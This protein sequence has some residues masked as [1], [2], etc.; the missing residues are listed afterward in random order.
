[1]DP[2]TTVKTV[3]RSIPE[4]APS[5]PPPPNP[6]L[7]NLIK[8]T[9]VIA[10]AAPAV[11]EETGVE[12]HVLT[13]LALKL[14]NTV[15]R[16]TSDWAAQQLRLPLGVVDRIFWQLR[17][18]LLLEILGQEEGNFRYSI[19]QR[20]R[21]YA[22]RL[23]E[24][25]GYVGPAPVSLESYA[26]ML[27]WQM[28]K[29]GRPTVESVTEAISSLVLPQEAI[30][31]AS[32]AA[33]SGRSLF[34]FGPPGNGKTSL[35]R[36]LHGVLEGEL[37]IPHCVS[38][39]SHIIRIFDPQCHQLVAPSTAGDAR[40]D[41]RWLRIRRPMIIAGGE[42]TIAELD[43]AYS[44]SLRFYEAPPHVKA[45]GGLFLL[46][47]FGRQRI[48]SVDLLNRWI[49][50]LE[51]QVDFL[52]LATGQKIRI[53]FRLMLIVATNLRVDETS[54]PAF[55]R[56]IGYRLHLDRPDE[57]RYAEI[58][59]RYAE[60][61]GMPIEAA[62]VASVLKRYRDENRELRASEPRDLIERCRD[63]CT[64]RRQP[65]RIDAQLLDLA[66]SGYFGVPT[67]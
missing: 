24:I 33:S 3:S 16:L 63:I 13:D 49:I 47:D 21:D 15:P 52:T 10:P 22:R 54:D 32:L 1:L 9:G 8:A 29:Q 59:R 62:L 30:E 18:D 4:P 6:H 56:R 26:A 28:S 25:S 11:I 66:W 2:T 37:W 19:T 58:F 53:P 17:D 55:L 61:A 36:M 44:P 39:E 20:G 38:I 41:Q 50:P 7:P 12:P 43:L 40:I 27:E 51:H 31:V 14:C 48:T 64:L 45:N 42:M 35:G 60:S 57:Q 46:D 23:L 34:L 5:A 65:P 67:H